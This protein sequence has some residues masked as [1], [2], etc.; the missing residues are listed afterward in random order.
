MID[1]SKKHTANNL[2]QQSVLLKSGSK[3]TINVA[4]GIGGESSCI[5][6][7]N[8]SCQSALGDHNSSEQLFSTTVDELKE[9]SS[10][11]KHI[12]KQR[13]KTLVNKPS[14]K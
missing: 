2:L 3:I 1:Q 11:I 9:L 12:I 14:R 10:T 6:L 8:N 5:I 7:N 13:N 4:T